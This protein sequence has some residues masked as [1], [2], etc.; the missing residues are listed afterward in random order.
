[1]PI[2]TGKISIPAL[3][4]IMAALLPPERKFSATIAV[5]SWPV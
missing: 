1:M 4:H 3:S 2:S 5:T